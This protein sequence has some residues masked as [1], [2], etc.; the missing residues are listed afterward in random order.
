MNTNQTKEESTSTPE[1]VVGVENNPDQDEPIP[2]PPP[3]TPP[4]APLA[5][6]KKRAV[7]VMMIAAVLFIVIIA[8][9]SVYILLKRDSPEPATPIQPTTSYSENKPEPSPTPNQATTPE[10][11]PTITET[12]DSLDTTTPIQPTNPPAATPQEIGSNQPPPVTIDPSYNPPPMKVNLYPDYQESNTPNK[13]SLIYPLGGEIFCYGDVVEVKWHPEYL[14]GSTVDIL[15]N[16]PSTVLRLDTVRTTEGVY[17]WYISKDHVTSTE[18][19][20]SAP[21]EPGDQYSINLQSNSTR[22]GVDMS[23]LFTIA[24]VCTKS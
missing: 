18:Q 1:E 15:L 20:G 14:E 23:D 12:D 3:P 8:S 11:T 22:R 7:I 17:Y 6:E 10:P 13:Q 4:A 16:T 21:I 9:A 5:P 24:S 19:K 2:A